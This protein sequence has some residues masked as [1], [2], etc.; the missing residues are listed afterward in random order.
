MKSLCVI[1]VYNEDTKLKK[2]I[3]L[4]KKNPHKKYNLDYLFVNNGSND[5]SISLIRSSGLKYINL[6]KNWG[7]G[8]ALILGLFYAIKHKYK[9]IIHLA[10]NGKMHPK[11]IKVFLKEIIKKNYDFVNG[12]RFLKGG[13]YKKNPIIRII[14]IK[15]YSFILSFIFKKKITDCSCGYRAF[16]VE[17]FKNKIK[18]LFNKKLYSYG[19]EYYSYGL[20]AKENNLKI[21]EIPVSMNYP[22][23][24]YSKMKP[25]FDWFIIAKYWLIGYFDYL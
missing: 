7:V 15:F 18:K 14:L 25:V 12:S 19:Y 21:K 6:K 3:K 20:V 9:I 16:K 10:G 1:P 11:Y 13:I 17:I 22:D 2:L 23:K 4:I 5:N 24:N 8:Y